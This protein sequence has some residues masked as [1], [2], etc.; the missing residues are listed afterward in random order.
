MRDSLNKIAKGHATHEDGEEGLQRHISRAVS[1]LSLSLSHCFVE[2]T[3]AKSKCAGC[4]RDWGGECAEE[5]K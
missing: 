4:N 5:P 1:S 3:E 2:S